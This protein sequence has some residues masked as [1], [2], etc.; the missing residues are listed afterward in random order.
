MA[1]FRLVCIVLF[2]ALFSPASLSAADRDNAYVTS[3]TAS[4]Q[5]VITPPETVIVKDAP[6]DNGASIIVTWVKKTEEA[7]LTG[8]EI[9][10]SETVDGV[11]APVADVSRGTFSF[12]DN[13]VTK[14][15]SYYYKI[16]AMADSTRVFTPVF[17]PVYA[18]AQ[19]FDTSKTTALALAI[20]LSGMIIVLIAVSQRGTKLYV[21][22]I[23][24]L[25]AVEEAIG[26]AT[27][28]GR[29]LLFVPGIMDIDNVQTLAGLT[30]L[31]KVAKT[32]AEY[33][34]RLQV[35]CSR[36]LVMTTAREMVKEA[37]LAA[38]R[39]DAFHD[40]AIQ[41]LT[42]E[43][44]GYVAGVNGMIVREKPATI[45][46]MGA[47]YAE[48]LILAETG[49]A[50]GAIQIAGT[51]MPSQLPFFVAACDY[52]LLGEEL[53]AASAYLSG[54]P[55]QLGSL[56][57]QDFGKVIAMF[58]IVS[59]SISATLAQIFGGGIFKSITDLFFRWFAL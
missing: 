47:F 6:N 11:F 38:G 40:D 22:R 56:K 26:R 32:V 57:G 41:Y 44:F 51:A 35:P 7:P 54:D 59:G 15:I 43:Q 58:F 18:S 19:W 20:L 50:S 1:V 31:H 9:L 27:E 14:N 10:R 23:A 52:T 30:I 16:A 49:N 55:K 8:Y 2:I 39:P 33:D 37:Y 42:D 13:T 36:S 24:G 5:A 53:F 34:S 17:G 12:N 48:S 45:F 29:P 3:A 28:M 21:R 25:S 4:R 46:Y